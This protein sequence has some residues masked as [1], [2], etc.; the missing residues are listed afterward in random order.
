MTTRQILNLLFR[1]A[2]L[3]AA[4]VL[5]FFYRDE[6]RL[7]IIEL[8]KLDVIVFLVVPL[9]VV[10]NWVASFAWL[11]LHAR[12]TSGAPPS[13]WKLS[14]I[15]L[16]AQAINLLVPLASI[17]GEILRAS[18]LSRQTGQTAG[19]TSAV[20]LD[21]IAD[22][23][24]GILFALLGLLLALAYGVESSGTTAMVLAGMAVVS[25]ILMPLALRRFA[26][27][28][29]R[30]ES[31]FSRS[32]APIL[33]TPGLISVGFYRALTWHLVERLLTA[34]EIYVAMLALGVSSGPVDAIFIAAVM[35][36][37]SLVFFFVPGQVGAIEA[38]IVSACASLGLP[39]S[40]ALTIALV[41]RARQV[42]MIAAGALAFWG[43]AGQVR[44]PSHD[45]QPKAHA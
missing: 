16:Q 38:G 20:I 7:A 36:A 5:V 44:T 3:I 22:T 43:G 26:G 37:Y 35:T 23:S 42:L 4:G 13:A 34:G 39:A 17:G 15:R 8:T 45:V 27:I 40:T 25:V 24:A 12:L 18:I 6:F 29:G 21:K 1:G 31:W 19:T 9:F 41:R 32:L 33:E 30:G 2:T 28:L 14:L 11:E 10:W